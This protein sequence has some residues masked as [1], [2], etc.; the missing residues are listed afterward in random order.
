M[1]QNNESSGEKASAEAKGP[2]EVSL[3]PYRSEGVWVFT[4]HL[5][6][7]QVAEAILEEFGTN[8]SITLPDDVCYVGTHF[9]AGFHEVLP[10][11]EIPTATVELPVHA[12]R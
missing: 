11:A 12:Q 8:V 7:T 5:R 2:T 1:S 6:G 9:R 4:G 3:D 10:D